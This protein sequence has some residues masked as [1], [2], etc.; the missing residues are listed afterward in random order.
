M[1]TWHKK[2]N[3]RLNTTDVAGKGMSEGAKGVF[4]DAGEGA[5]DSHTKRFV[6]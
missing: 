1:S 6:S 2:R 4:A 3:R 5:G